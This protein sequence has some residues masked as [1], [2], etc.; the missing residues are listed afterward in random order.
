M[1]ETNNEKIPAIPHGKEFFDE[2]M[3]GIE[4]DLVLSDEQREA[5]YVGES[6][7]DRAARMKRY[8]EKFAEYDKAAAARLSQ[9]SGN[10]GAS[11]RNLRTGAETAS[12]GREEA[13]LSNLEA[14]FNTAA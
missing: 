10:V 7:T 2:V 5:K 1:S 13:D 9:L 8:E 6:E 14:H 12:R 3:G 4:P 11:I